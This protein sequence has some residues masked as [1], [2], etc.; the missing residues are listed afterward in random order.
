MFGPSSNVN[1][2]VWLLA[3]DGSSG[4]ASVTQITMTTRMEAAIM[5]RTMGRPER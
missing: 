4:V 5:V 2:M 1:A 3:N